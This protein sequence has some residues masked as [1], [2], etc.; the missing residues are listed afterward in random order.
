M[1]GGSD[2]A[3]GADE[4]VDLAQLAF[5]R[6]AVARRALQAAHGIA[7]LGAFERLQQELV[8]SGAHAL[9]HGLAIGAE[10]AHHH[11][12]VGRR[13]FHLLD[14]LDGALGIARDVHDQAGVRMALQ[15]LQDAN[16]EVGGHLL[17]FGDNLRLGKID[18]VVAHHLAEMFVAGSDQ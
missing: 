5:P 10:I 18:Q 8:G 14:G 11:E 4:G 13:L 9:N 7:E 3:L 1:R 17:V 2:A 15:I 16:V 6:G 12:Q